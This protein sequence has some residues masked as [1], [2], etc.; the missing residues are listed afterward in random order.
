MTASCPTTAWAAA[1]SS[2]TPTR[3]CSVSETAEAIRG[4]AGPTPP[5]ASSPRRPCTP[6]RWRVVTELATQS[7][8]AS[9]AAAGL[10][11]L[12]RRPSRCDCGARCAGRPPDGERPGWSTRAREAVLLTLHPGA[13]GLWLQLG[14]PLRAG[15]RVGARRLLPAR[16][17]KRVALDSLVLDPVPL[18]LDVHPITCSLGIPERV[19]STCVTSP[20]APARSDAVAQRRVPSICDGFG[21]EDLPEGAAADLP[22]LITLARLRLS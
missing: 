14:G 15:R 2:A 10:S 22:A 12:S 13:A 8:E 6:T 18:G 11:R 19:T 4:S 5:A 7:G 3:I 17:V 9:R 20:F 21:W 16:P 1:C